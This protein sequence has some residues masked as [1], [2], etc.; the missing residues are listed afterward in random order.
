MY[1]LEQGIINVNGKTEK[2]KSNEVWY[3]VPTLGL[4]I[5]LNEAIKACKDSDYP[6]Q[7]CIIPV[8]VAVGETQYELLLK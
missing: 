1:D 4:F 3:Q 8:P 2:I 5:D 6:T 7:T